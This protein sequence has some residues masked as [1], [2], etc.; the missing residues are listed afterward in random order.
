MSDLMQKAKLLP[1]PHFGVVRLPLELLPAYY[2][3]WNIK[4]VAGSW[5]YDIKEH[6]HV[7]HVHR[8]S[9]DSTTKG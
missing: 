5:H 2:Q 8:E 3:L 9:D 7:L 6:D 4:V 1:P